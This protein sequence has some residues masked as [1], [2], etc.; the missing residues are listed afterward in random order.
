[1]KYSQVAVTCMTEISFIVTLNNQFNH[2]IVKWD[3]TTYEVFLLQPQYT[4][5]ILK[6]FFSKKTLNISL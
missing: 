4:R 5:A 3:E 2:S 1:M 6:E